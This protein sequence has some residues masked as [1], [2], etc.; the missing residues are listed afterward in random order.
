MLFFDKNVLLLL[1]VGK[2]CSLQDLPV[3]ISAM[4]GAFFEGHPI[5]CGGWTTTWYNRCF[6]YE[7]SNSTWI[8]VCNMIL[9]L[10]LDIYLYCCTLKILTLTQIEHC[11]KMEYY[12]VL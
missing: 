3:G 1:H 5:S 9:I 2:I 8:Q 12:L 6:I 4:V 10:H 7:P 11:V